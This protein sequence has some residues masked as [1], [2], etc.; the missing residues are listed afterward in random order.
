VAPPRPPG[1][2]SIRAGGAPAGR[3][4]NVVAPPLEGR[5][6]YAA[7]R[8]PRKTVALIAGGAL[9][10]A[11]VV[12]ALTSLGGSK[13]GRAATNAATTTAQRAATHAAKRAHKAASKPAPKAP[14][15]SPAETT[16]A[17]LNAT[18]A[19]GLAR[20]LA[21]TLQQNGYSQATA[22][23]GKPPGSDQ[24]S[25]VEYASGHQ[26]EAEGV[27]HS[28]SVTHVLPIEAA[29]TAL[30]GSANVVVIVGADKEKETS[31]P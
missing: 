6:V 28:I 15:V 29:V 20:R 9:V 16:V 5:S 1:G 26:A 11:A 7:R 30:A 31:S 24:V 17:V 23:Y 22:L 18:E 21:S 27:A 25:V 10:V 3:R 4:A 12:V 19:E 8:S 2:Q 14:A 13:G